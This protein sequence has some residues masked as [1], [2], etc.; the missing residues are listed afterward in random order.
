MDLQSS[1]TKINL[2]RAFAGE[3]MA[4]NRYNMAATTAFGEGYHAIG[5]IFDFTAKQEQAHAT[6]FYGFLKDVNDT[7]FDICAAYPVNVYDTTQKHLEAAVKNEYEEYESAY[8]SFGDTAKAEGFNTIANAFYMISEIEKI[9]GDRFDLFLKALENSTLCKGS[10]ESIWVC[11]NCGHIHTGPAV[12]A[13]CPVCSHPQGYFV[14]D[15][16]K[17]KTTILL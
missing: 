3:S 14:S 10:D 16:F 1:Q 13:A 9:H 12:P 17:E 8:K 7:N 15:C 2:M 11:T 6:V 4:R 5:R